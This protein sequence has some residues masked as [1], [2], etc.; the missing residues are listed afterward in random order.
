M[1]VKIVGDETEKKYPKEAEIEVNVVDILHS[2]KESLGNNQDCSDVEKTIDLL[3]KQL[4]A[5]GSL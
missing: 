2:I 1:F 3:I 4:D 5:L